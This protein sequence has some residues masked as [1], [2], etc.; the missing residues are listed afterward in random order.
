[1]EGESAEG[2]LGEEREE[3]GPKEAEDVEEKAEEE[4]TRDRNNESDGKSS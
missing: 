2:I 3:R 4:S 1:M